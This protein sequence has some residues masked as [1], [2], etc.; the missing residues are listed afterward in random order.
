MTKY[1]KHG[2][3]MPA[4]AVQTP[5]PWMRNIQTEGIW[6]RHRLAWHGL[7]H[8]VS[9]LNH[10]STHAY[11]IITLLLDKY[12]W[13]SVIIFPKSHVK[14]QTKGFELTKSYLHPPVPDVEKPQLLHSLRSSLFGSS[15]P[16]PSHVSTSPGKRQHLA[17][18]P[19]NL[20]WQPQ[21]MSIS[22]A[23]STIYN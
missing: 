1:D 23:S 22:N 2:P 18:T 16:G 4:D 17:C 19:W 7:N 20:E 10:H 5:A 12:Q 3:C 15:L 8:A 13:Y 6:I 14:F 11:I 21:N 9:C